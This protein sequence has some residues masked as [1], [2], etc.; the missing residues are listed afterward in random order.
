MILVTGATGLVG[1]Q[2][3]FDLTSQGS[4]VVAM[5]RSTSNMTVFNNTFKNHQNLTEKINWVKA[6]LLDPLSLE[7]ALINIDYV[8]HCAAFVSFDSKEVNKVLEINIDGTA[9]LVNACLENGVKHFCHV[10][11]VSALGNKLVNGKLTEKAEAFSFKNKSTYAIS[12]HKA[13]REVWRARAEGLK[14]FVVSPTIIFGRGDWN[15]GSSALFT[16]LNKGFPFYTSGVNGFVDVRD[17]SNCMIRLMKKQIDGETY[18][19][20]SENLSYKEIFTL[21]AQALNKKPPFIKPPN[22]LNHIFWRLEYFRSKISGYPPV[23]TR[24]T[25]A[26][27]MTKSY[28]SNEKIKKELNYEFI[29]IK[30]SVKN[31]CKLFLEDQQ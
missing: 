28:F 10:S 12:K 25:V 3:L 9:N 15:T 23:I 27:S 20:C 8:Y 2:L 1:V 19:L 24:E 31:T 4:T 26:T 17:V 14:A 13:E 6:D 5:K 7:K 22:W 16:K 29:T 11:S 30:E 21:T 18:I